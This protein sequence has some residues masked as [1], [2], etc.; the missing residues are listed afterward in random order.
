M[1][2]SLTKYGVYIDDLSKIRVLEPEAANQTNKLKEECQ[3]FV[4]SGL[5]SLRY[6]PARRHTIH[7]SLHRTACALLN[8]FLHKKARTSTLSDDSD[9]VR[10]RFRALIDSTGD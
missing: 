8:E 2:D 10:G 1:A 9:G 3:S 5:T 6:S 7:D 4:S